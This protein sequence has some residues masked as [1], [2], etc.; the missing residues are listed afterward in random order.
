LRR[1][2]SGIDVRPALPVAPVWAT[3]MSGRDNPLREPS[4]VQPVTRLSALGDDLA[5]AYHVLRN[6][7]PGAHWNETLEL[8]RLGL[9]PDVDVLSPPDAGAGQVGLALMIR[10]RKRFAVQLS[11]GTLSYLA[12]VAACRLGEGRSVLVL[13]EPDAHLH[14]ALHARVMTLLEVV[15]EQHPVVVTTHSDTLLDCL[16]DPVTSTVVCDLTEAG[17]TRL[18]ALDEGALARW[19]GDYRG[20]GA[21]RADGWLGQVL[22]EAG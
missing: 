1:L 12:L 14:P 18:R 13:D 15:A 8:V 11:D 10:G 17:E 5:A 7:R 3:R 9:G 21:I 22:D 20:L 6:D 16:S 19:M 4:L 2:L